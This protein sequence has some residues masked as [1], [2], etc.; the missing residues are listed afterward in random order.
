MSLGLR[1][2]ALDPSAFRL[3]VHWLLRLS[4]ILSWRIIIHFQCLCLFSLI[5]I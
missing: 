1:T 4:C 5:V 2:A 3:I